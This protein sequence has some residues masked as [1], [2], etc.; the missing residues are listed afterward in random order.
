[1]RLPP[2]LIGALIAALLLGGANP[3]TA[4]EPA[5]VSGY[6]RDA[7]T[8]ET[9]LQANVVIEGTG[10]GA[11]TNNAGFYTIQELAPGAYTFVVSYVGY[12]SR[13]VDVKLEVGEARRLNVELVPASLEADEV[14]VTGAREQTEQT[15]GVDQLPAASITELPSVLEPDVFRSLALLP[16]VA[17]ASDYS[18][19]LYIRGGGPAQTLVQ[20]DRT[21]VYNPTHFFGFY[22]TFNPNAIKDVQLY[23]GAYPA[24][25]GG[26]LG[27]VVDIYNKDGNRRETSGGLSLGLL[28]SRS[29]LEGPFGSGAS[30][31]PA[32]SYMIAVRRSTLEPLLAALD[33]VEGVPE[34]FYFYDV[35][36]KVNY[37]AG[38]DDKLSLAVYGGRDQ[39]NLDLGGEGRADVQYGNRTVS[40]DWTHLFSDRVFSTVTLAGSRYESSPVFEFGGTRFTQANEV[41]DVSLKADLDYTPGG[42]HTVETG[43][44]ASLLTFELRNTFDENETFDQRL[45]GEKVALYLKDTYEPSETWTVRVGLRGTYFSEGPFWRLSP[46]V[47]VKYALTPSVRLQA[48][49]GRY[50]QFLTLETSQVLTAF[51]TWLMADDGVPPSYGDQFVLGADADLGGTWTLEVEGYA[52]TMRGLFEQNPFLPDQAGVPYAERFHFGDGRAY[53]GEVLLRRPEGRVN[54]FLSYT[55]GRTERRFPNVN[56]SETGT[57]QYYPPNFDR[58][59]TLTLA[60]NYHFADGWRLSGTFEYATGQAYTRPSHRYQLVNRPFPFGAG[61]GGSGNVLV[62]PFN[63]ARLPAY[64]RLDLGLARTGRF[65]GIADYE[66]QLQAINAYGRRNIW[67]YQYEAESDGTLSRNETPQIPVPLPNLSFSL[68][69]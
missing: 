51:D 46:R 68:T 55:L 56:L 44:D 54:G 30:G 38:P 61:S 25:Y 60:A 33:G 23:K 17:T 48:A 37:D 2:V 5:S 42:H 36:A 1:M 22:S 41:S 9:L 49:Y 45:R 53:G 34:S 21:T 40:L 67:F 14:V 26:R 39:L 69:F 11:A 13:S 66:L 63:N 20:L 7:S 50:H 6:V 62:S 15:I 4:Q 18:S 65:F 3:A 59:H 58:T 10:R 52:R 24:E 64:H 28:A 29:Y 16:G 57:P 35:N 12:Q 47:S 31:D 19:N 8:G 32:G 43:L 27:S